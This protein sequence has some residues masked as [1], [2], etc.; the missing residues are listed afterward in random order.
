MT[1]QS[2]EQLKEEVFKLL[3][4][5][6][7]FSE[8][9]LVQLSR[10][11]SKKMKGQESHL[12]SL[13]AELHLR[14]KQMAEGAH[15]DRKVSWCSIYKQGNMEVKKIIAGYLIKRIHVFRGYM[16]YMEVNDIG[17]RTCIHKRLS[18]VWEWEIATIDSAEETEIS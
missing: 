17:V 15:D 1:L 4:G 10:D 12:K 13:R 9:L 11:L 7:R 6:S 16:I 2:Y 14:R 8:E 5:E 18:R 3:T